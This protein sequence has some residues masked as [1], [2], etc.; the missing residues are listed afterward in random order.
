MDHRATTTGRPGA[1]GLDGAATPAVQLWSGGKDSAMALWAAR[2]R[3][4]PDVQALATT[5]AGRVDRS[6][7]HGVRTGLMRRQAA[8]VGLPLHEVRLADP[9]TIDE[10]MGA[11]AGFLRSAEAAP[12]GAVVWGDLFWDEARRRH[13]DASAG[14]GKT[15]VYPLWGRDTAELAHAVIDAGF[16]AIVAS[17]DLSRLDASFAGRAYDAAFLA[18]LPEGIDPCAEAGESH[19][20][21]WDGSVFRAPV[22]MRRVRIA[23]RGRHRLLRPGT[24]GLTNW[25]GGGDA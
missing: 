6:T 22:A 9:Y 25:A 12:Y 17:V 19:T 20:F 5:V 24:G 13:E 10:L 3:G 14:A 4:E 8:A 16:Q 7:W 2:Q 18:D 21:G 11:I 23:R 1:A 15:V